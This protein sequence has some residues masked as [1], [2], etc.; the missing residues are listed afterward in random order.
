MVPRGVIVGRKVS[1][2]PYSLNVIVTDAP[3]P[4]DPGWTVGYGNSPPARKLACLLL[5]VTRF[6]SA[7]ISSRFLLSSA[8]IAACRLMSFRIAKKVTNGPSAP[9]VAGPV[10]DLFCD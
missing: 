10:R 2:M 6:G 1:R 4:D 5:T 7:R 3:L 8:V 9:A